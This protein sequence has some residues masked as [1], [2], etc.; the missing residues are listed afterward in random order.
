M[1]A[2]G[3]VYPTEVV[4]PLGTACLLDA[5]SG[6]HWRDKVLHYACVC[7]YSLSRMLT[8]R[9]ACWLAVH[10][11][12]LCCSLLSPILDKHTQDMLSFQ[13]IKATW[14]PPA[15]YCQGCLALVPPRSHQ[16]LHSAKLFSWHKSSNTLRLP[17]PPTCMVFLLANLDCS[18]QRCPGTPAGPLQHLLLAL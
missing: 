6:L 3:I 12:P 17:N 9:T 15:A 18:S 4:Q 14:L 2:K 8:A 5:S 16:S 1:G 10:L 13:P 7:I 11:L